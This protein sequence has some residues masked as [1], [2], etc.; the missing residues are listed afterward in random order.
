MT[1]EI[2]INFFKGKYYYNLPYHIASE[3]NI[4]YLQGKI[5]TYLQRK[6]LIQ[7]SNKCKLLYIQRNYIQN[8]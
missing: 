6:L 4:N 1:S 5:L 8:C 3:I 2:Y 7:I